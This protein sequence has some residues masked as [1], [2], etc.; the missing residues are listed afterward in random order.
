[1]KLVGIDQWER[2]KEF[3]FHVIIVDSKSALFIL[4]LYFQILSSINLSFTNTN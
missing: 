2:V 3:L 4:I 1:M